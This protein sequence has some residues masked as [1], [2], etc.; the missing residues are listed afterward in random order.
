MSL[1]LNGPGTFDPSTISDLNA[2]SGARPIE[3]GAEGQSTVE[4]GAKCEQEEPEQDQRPAGLKLPGNTL[5]SSPGRPLP[6]P[7]LCEAPR[8]A[9]QSF[10]RVAGYVLQAGDSY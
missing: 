10:L 3:I 4:A 5:S 6:L 7:S 2:L 8:Y 9:G 1:E